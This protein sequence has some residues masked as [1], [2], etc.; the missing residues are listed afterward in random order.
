MIHP[1]IRAVLVAILLVVA[2][3]ESEVVPSKGNRE[4][5]NPAEVK[6]YQ[7]K[8]KKYED[9]GSVE[10]PVGGDVK[11]DEKGDATAGF[12]R[13]KSQ[14]AQRGAN[15]VLLMTDEPSTAMVTAGTGGKYYRVPVRT[16]PKS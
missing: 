13:L 5:T 15:G 11:W 10:V 2:G 6:I 16:N 9:L 3:C 1:G 4:P 14:A 8:P 12:D 7:E